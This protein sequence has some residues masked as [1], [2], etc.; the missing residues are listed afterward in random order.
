LQEDNYPEMGRMTFMMSQRDFLTG[1]EGNAC[2]SMRRKICLQGHQHFR[3]AL[4]GFL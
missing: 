2:P 4:A 1:L 3:E